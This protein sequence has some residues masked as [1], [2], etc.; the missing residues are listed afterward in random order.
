M[1]GMTLQRVVESCDSQDDKDWVVL[2]VDIKNAFDSI[3][4]AA[5]LKAKDKSSIGFCLAALVLF[6]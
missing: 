4:R 3:D 6:T 1:V 5:L 2:Q